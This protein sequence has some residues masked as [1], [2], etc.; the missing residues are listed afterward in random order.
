MALLKGAQLRVDWSHE[1]RDWF[2][3]LRRELKG[4]PQGPGAEPLSHST[5]RCHLSWGEHPFP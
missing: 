1:S 3:W 5:L 4:Q 2:V